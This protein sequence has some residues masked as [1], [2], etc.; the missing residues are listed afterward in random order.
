[1]Q[2]ASNQA[3]PSQGGAILRLSTSGADGQSF[4]IS[5]HL[6][7]HPRHHTGT[8]IWG[9]HSCRDESMFY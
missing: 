3:D 8:S 4:G 1:M 6:R 9:V 2:S 5:A 7:E